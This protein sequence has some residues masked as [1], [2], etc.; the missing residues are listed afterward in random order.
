VVDGL[1]DPE[2]PC[3]LVALVDD[4]LL[5]PEPPCPVVALVDCDFE[6]PWDLVEDAEWPALDDEDG[7]VLPL[8]EADDP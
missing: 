7:W 8:D 1:L 2:P 6:E 3:P 5:D 4:G